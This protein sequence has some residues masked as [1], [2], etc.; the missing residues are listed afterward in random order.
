MSKLFTFLFRSRAVDEDSKRRE[1]ILNVL[2][3]GALIIFAAAA[4]INTIVSIARPEVTERSSHLAVS[5]LLIICA[6]VLGLYVVSRK[7]YYRVS[8]HILIG[9]FFFFASFMGYMWGAEVTAALLIHMVVIVMAGILINTRFTFIVTTASVFVLF[10]LQKLQSTGVIVADTSWKV[11]S[12]NQQD[13]IMVCILF[14]IT[15]IISWLSNREIEA[16]LAR[17][18]RSEASL[19]I[20]RDSLEI[21]VEERTKELKEA[22]LEQVSQLYSFAEFGRLSSGLFHDLMN[23]LT[24]VSLNVERAKKEGESFGDI[25]RTQHYLDQAFVAAKRMEQFISAIR[26]QIGKHGEKREFSVVEEASQVLDILA[27]KA[28]VA[29]VTL[30]LVAPQDCAIVGDPMRFNQVLLNL[31]TNAIDAY[32]CKPEDETGCSV[33][34]TVEQS[35]AEIICT[36]ADRGVG[37]DQKN[38]ENIFKPFFTTKPNQ[39]TKGTGIGLSIVKTII[40]KD[41]NGTI[42]VVST[43]DTGTVFTVVL[44][45]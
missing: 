45:S 35:G 36:V 40:E 7:G 44:R 12:W 4:T 29:G 30:N 18:H 24:A 6:V 34:V 3:L 25:T 1:F 27:Y 11:S 32:D 5:P 31:V 37:I 10:I 26:K 21:T 22:Q 2:L 15:A 9:I 28:H 13:T 42:T 43:P 23:P 17:A 41:F 38:I 33:V 19:R 14:S 20:E 8:A 39:K 16:S